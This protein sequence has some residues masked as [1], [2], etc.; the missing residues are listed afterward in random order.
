MPTKRTQE[1][2]LETLVNL[3]REMA[4]NGCDVERAQNTIRANEDILR[5][6]RKDYR[7]LRLF[8]Q[9][10]VVELFINLY[11]EP[12]YSMSDIESD[13]TLKE[14]IR[15]FRVDT[16]I[17]NTI[18]ADFGIEVKD[19]KLFF[20][21]KLPGAGTYYLPGTARRDAPPDGWNRVKPSGDMLYHLQK[22]L[23]KRFPNL[24]K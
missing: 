4:F 19:G 7:K 16:R 3:D 22:I 8:E 17:H 9:K 18:Q 14:I 1:Q 15:L 2:I 13:D 11:P 6:A 10:T 5:K 23:E 21:V 24:Y 20:L 12:K